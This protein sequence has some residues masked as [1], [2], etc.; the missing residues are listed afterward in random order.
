MNDVTASCP[1]Q[2]VS[3][4]NGGGLCSFVSAEKN[5]FGIV[6]L[7]FGNDLLQFRIT[8]TTNIAQSLYQ[9]TVEVVG[10]RCWI[11]ETIEILV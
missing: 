8:K 10:R 6:V 5:S 3:F 11:Q 1:P 2:Y 7:S 4:D 9:V